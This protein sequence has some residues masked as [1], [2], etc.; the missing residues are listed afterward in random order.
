MSEED[1]RAIVDALNE[2][3]GFKVLVWCCNE[4]TT[5]SKFGLK[6]VKLV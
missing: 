3:A 5:I 1:N 6:G 2:T 4:K